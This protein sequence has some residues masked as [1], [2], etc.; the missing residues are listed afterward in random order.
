MTSEP[1]NTE[2]DESPP[3]EPVWDR[4][5]ARARYRRLMRSW[6]MRVTYVLLVLVILFSW[7]WGI[8][9]AFAS[10]VETLPGHDVTVPTQACITCHTTDAARYAAPPMSHPA[11]PSCGFCHRQSLPESGA[12]PGAWH[13]GIVP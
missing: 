12:S 6:P 13:A 4:E 11:A 7:A 5:A 2:P 8:A 1:H 3:P 9:A 10:S